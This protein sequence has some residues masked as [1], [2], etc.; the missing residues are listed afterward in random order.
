M[1]QRY[2]SACGAGLWG[3]TVSRVVILT[4]HRQDRSVT[5]L[6]VPVYLGVY[7]DGGVIHVQ[8]PVTNTV[9][10]QDRCVASLPGACLSGCVPGEV[11]D[12]WYS[13]DTCNIT[14]VIC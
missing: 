13:G 11:Q 1:E 6:L 9:H 7:Q 8:N 10:R 2:P 4:V 12:N 5:S 3:I 14:I